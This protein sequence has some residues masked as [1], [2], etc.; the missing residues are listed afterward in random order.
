VNGTQIVRGDQRAPRRARR[1]GTDYQR[2]KIQ[3]ESLCYEHKKHDGSYPIV[4]VNTFL[5]KH[6]DGVPN[7]IELARSTEEEKQSQLKRLADFHARNAKAA[8]RGFGALETRGDRERQRL[9][10]AHEDRARVLPRTDNQG[11]VRSGW[12]VSAEHVVRA[13]QFAET[14]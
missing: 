14:R 5:A 3:E 12:G 6:S 7:K 9:R 8:P 2:G 11:A 13:S 4:G 10:R 1:E